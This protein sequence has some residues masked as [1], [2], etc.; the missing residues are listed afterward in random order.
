MTPA[1]AQRRTSPGRA[2][3]PIH[4]Q[5]RLAPGAEPPTVPEPAAAAA[6]ALAG[7]RA[8]LA[9]APTRRAA[10]WEYFGHAIGPCES[11]GEPCRSTAPDG[12]VLHPNWKLDPKCGVEMADDR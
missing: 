3:A 7:A 10:G 9:T 11:C 2:R 1:R 4:V 12:R 6:S 8:K 5:T